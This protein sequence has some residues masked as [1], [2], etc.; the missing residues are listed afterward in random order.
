M[1]SIYI[2]IQTSQHILSVMHEYRQSDLQCIITLYFKGVELCARSSALWKPFLR[3]Q[4]P[5]AVTLKVP[6][7]ATRSYA[8]KAFT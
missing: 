3:G 5:S 1:V 7:I 8:Y 2:H 6:T 4:G